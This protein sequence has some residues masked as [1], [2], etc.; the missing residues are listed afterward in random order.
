[1]PVTPTFGKQ[2]TFEKFKL[3]IG[4]YCYL[5]VSCVAAGSSLIIIILYIL[6]YL[7]HNIVI[8]FP[9]KIL[10][11]VPKYDIKTQIFLT[12]RTEHRVI[13]VVRE[14]KKFGNCQTRAI[15]DCNIPYTNMKLFM[16][17]CLQFAN[18][19]R[20]EVYLLLNAFLASF[21]LLRLH[22]IRVGFQILVSISLA[23]CHFDKVT[24]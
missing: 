3:R 24:N 18:C 11:L 13:Q 1:V 21:P 17:R 14:L 5:R 16:C 22:R 2:N 20:F 9:L 10:I 15:N 4:I 8:I 6:R 23:Y 19:A 12:F 7:G